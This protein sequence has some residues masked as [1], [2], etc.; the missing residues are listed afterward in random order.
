MYRSCAYSSAVREVRHQPGAQAVVV[1]LADLLVDLAPPDLVLL[2]GSRTMNLS[3]GDRPCA[4]RSG[5]RAGPSAAIVPSRA[6]DRALVELGDGEVRQD[7]AA[8]G[9]GVGA[10]LV[11][12]T[13]GDLGLRRGRRA[14][15][16]VR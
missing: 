5:R 15:A 9:L 2:D 10:G 1:R 6:R 7:A 16:V 4:C 14:P 3:R 12:V 8:D 13:I 11:I